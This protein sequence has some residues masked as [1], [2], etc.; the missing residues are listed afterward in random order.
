MGKYFGTDGFRGEAGVGLTAE[1]AFKI[2][3]FLGWYYG[4]L[5]RLTRQLHPGDDEPC[6]ARIV[7]GKD[8]R[9]SSYMLEY[10][11]ASGIAASGGDA[12]TMHVTTTPSVA[13]VARTEDF[14]CGVMVSASHNPYYDNGIKL[15]DGN[16]EKAG[17]D[18]I[19]LVEA[20]LDGEVD[21]LGFKG[22]ELP[23]ATGAEVGAVEDHFAGRN[24]YVGFLISQGIFSLRG[25]RIGLDCANGA[26]WSIARSVFESMGAKVYTIGCEPDG[27]NINAGVGSTHIEALQE[28]VRAEGLDCGF[29]YDGDAD[30]CL[31]VD[32]HGNL[33]DG[34]KIMYICARY[35]KD[36][37]HLV[38]NEV[39]TTVMSNLGLYKALDEAGIEY[40]QTQVGDRYVWEHMR[41]SG[42]RIGGEQSGHIIFGK[43]ATTGDG[44]LTSIKLMEAVMGRKSTLG[45]L[46]APVHTYPQVLINV[47]VSDKKAAMADPDVVAA[48]A[49][50]ESALAG[51]GR[52]LVRASGTEPL[53]RVM[54]EA[55]TDEIAR[56]QAQR[57]VDVIREKGWATE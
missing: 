20:Y 21:C 25:K 34:D 52:A 44:I 51:D 57:V 41:T 23:W 33:I 49:S 56:E 8:T 9:R 6:R 29:A 55:A 35:M 14:D 37:G 48:A 18:L 1:H 32:E 27:T 36:K 13:Y 26:S 19:A 45:E 4:Q 43:L 42:G 15:M 38:P 5:K 31:A 28:L 54:V 50:V 3:R 17:D 40:A 24:R 7:L 22:F 12:Y 11:L 47:R 30:R 53:V 2:G 10:A 46:A 16:G 39:T